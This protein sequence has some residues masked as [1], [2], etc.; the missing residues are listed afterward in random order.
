M[1]QSVNAGPKNLVHGYD[2]TILIDLCKAIIEADRDG[3]LHSRQ[4]GIAK[5]ASLIVGASAKL[6]IRDLVYALS[7][8]DATREETI[9]AFRVYVADEAR[10]YETVQIT[11]DLA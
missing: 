3:A 10:E 5:Q 8:F 2:V 7:G 6:G 1:F 11:A 4:R 9:R